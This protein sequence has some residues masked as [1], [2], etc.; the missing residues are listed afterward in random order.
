M[1]IKYQLSILYGC[2]DIF[3]EKCKRKEKGTHTGKN[4]PDKPILNPTMQL[5]A[6]NLY[7][8]DELFGLQTE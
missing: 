6:V 2:G 7:T 5:I 4:K 3:D 1:H 8:K